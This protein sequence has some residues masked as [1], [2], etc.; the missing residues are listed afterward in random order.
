M[1]RAERLPFEI[2]VRTSEQR[3][4][5]GHN[6]PDLAIYD[7]GGEFIVA[8]VEV[9][10]PTVDLFELANSTD[11]ND[12]IGRYL[13]QTGV[14][15]LSNVRAFGL[16]TI[17][18][19]YNRNAA[20]PPEHRRLEEVVDLWASA[21]ALRL[22]KATTAAAP[23]DV[24]ALVETAA[25]RYAPIAEP[26]SLARILARL[27]RKAKADLPEEFSFAVRGL[28][29][30]FAKALGLTYEG[31]EGDAFL[32]SSLIQTAFYGLF[33]GW[34]LWHHSGAQRAFR[35]EDLSEYLKIPFLA[36]LF[37][38]FQHPVRLKDLG[39]RKHLDLATETLGRVDTGLFFSKFQVEAGAHVGAITYF[40]EPFLESFDPDLRKELGVWYTPAEIVRYQVRRVD[41]LLRSELGC[42]RGFA[43]KKVVVLDPCCGT[44]AYLMEVMS[45]IE[46]QLRSEGTEAILGQALMDAARNRVIGFEILTA[47]FVIAQLQM[48]L[49]LT[50]HGAEPDETSRPSI[51]LTNALT[52]WSGP[53][54]L[55][56]NFP[57]LQQEHDAAQQVKRE[58]KIIVIIGNPPY[59]R[60]AGV[61]VTEEADLIDTYKGIT[62]NQA[63]K[64]VGPSKLYT[65]WGI[66]KQLLDDLY[67]RFIRLAQ[68]CIGEKAEHGI[69]SFISNSSYLTGRSHPIMRESL[70]SEFSTIWIDNLHGNRLASERTPWG[71]SCETIFNVQGG[72]SGI[73]VGTCISTFIK[74]A[75]A[76]ES[77]RA[78]VRVRDCNCSRP[79]FCGSSPIV[80]SD[81]SGQ[82]SRNRLT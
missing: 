35:W 62:R 46:E 71:D 19:G 44:G 73:K 8:A 55:K 70:L 42:D 76:P 80:P 27:A 47:P 69:V 66:R 13:A 81:F 65:D 20:V 29:D 37:Y 18:P 4:Q 58:A 61:P 39:L 77:A 53:E 21:S 68:R 24:A 74:T 45:C 10:H 9:K 33:A 15:L 32:R 82:T 14:V 48:Y 34:T 78:V 16:L 49:R 54:Q 12:Q 36:Q 79:W 23:G 7:G 43:D 5:G 1:L 30:D 41:Q 72:G 52:G 38:E 59:N 60:F 51:F 50:A 75:Q 2:R 3:A 67:I 22:G 17:E 57:E 11:R 56:L 40:Y 28:L 64:A 31:E 26:E 25:T 6:Q 63:G